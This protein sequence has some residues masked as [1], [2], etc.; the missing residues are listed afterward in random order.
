MKI[1]YILE[2]DFEYPDELHDF[3]NDY[4]FAPEKLE[5]NDDMMSKYCSDIAKN[6]GIKVG[7]VTELISN[8][9]NSNKSKY[10]THYRNFHLYISLG[11]NFTKIHEVLKFRQSDSMK[12]YIDFITDKKNH[13]SS[14][15]KDFLSV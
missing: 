11:M 15:E 3:H 12:N 1:C 2:V 7:S 10:V 5:V 4:P 6:S 13:V 9:G 8:L 14:F